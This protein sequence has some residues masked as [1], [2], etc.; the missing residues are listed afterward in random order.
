[1]NFQRWRKSLPLKGAL[2]GLL[3]LG[4]G[5][6]LSSPNSEKPQ[7]SPNPDRGMYVY[8]AY[9]VG[10]HGESGRGDGPMA[11]KL[12]RDFSVRPGDLAAPS[13]QDSHNDKQIAEAIRGGG[14]AVHK[15]PYM[16]AW[17]STLTDRQVGDLVAYLRELKPRPVEVTATMVAVGDQLELGRVLYTIRCLACHGPEG[18]GNGPFLEGLTMGGSTLAVLPDFSKYETLR[19]RSDSDFEDLLVKGVSH[20]GLLPETEPGWWDRALEAD[21]A[22]ALI[23]YLRTLPMQSEKTRG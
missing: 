10:C 18:R 22:R 20:S 12:H 19:H 14:K 9:C 17:G 8:Q 11:G 1:M 3:L 16:P 21:E 4:G 13:Y 6:A 23:L 2:L 15:N 7:A 5:A